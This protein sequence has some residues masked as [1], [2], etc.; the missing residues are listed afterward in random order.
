M[1]LSAYIIVT[2][3]FCIACTTKTIQSTQH[4][5]ETFKGISPNIKKLTIYKNEFAI[6][7]GDNPSKSAN[8][9]V[10]NQI[11]QNLDKRKDSI[12]VLSLNLAH[13]RKTSFSQFFVSGKQIK[14]NIIE[15]G[16]YLRKQNS[17]VVFL[18]EADLPSRWS[19][20]F[21]HIE[22]LAQRGNYQ[23]FVATPHV[24][25]YFGVYG[26]AILSKFPI[27]EAIGVNFLPTP[28]T[29][30]KGFSLV[31]VNIILSD[32][33]KVDLDLLSVHL[34]FSRKSKRKEQ[35]LQMANILNK[36]DSPI[37]VG[38]DFNSGWLGKEKVVNNFVAHASFHA[39]A[40][41]SEDESFNTYG[42]NRIDWIFLSNTLQFN[43]YWV[44]SVELS[45]HKPLIAEISLENL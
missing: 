41:E 10:N 18:Q 12:S 40:E 44:D 45:D 43:Q 24:D 28:P 4:N 34:D 21:N 38:G 17:D 31:N 3:L 30:N 27:N 5:S 16:N 15:V 29:T 1:K 2:M 8:L 36:R 37:I 22:L 32:S 33:R 13:G 14:K 25:N 9:T 35:L 6:T 20:N 19:G 26:T 42:S 23:Y 7:K 39:F 11:T